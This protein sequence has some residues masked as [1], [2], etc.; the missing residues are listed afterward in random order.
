MTFISSPT[1]TPSVPL[2]HTHST[3]SVPARHN[4]RLQTLVDRINNDEEMRQLWR[5]A[6]VNAVERL[7]LS[8]HGETHIRIVANASLRMLRL[9]M[10]AGQQANIISQHGLGRE[11]AE[12]EVVLA[13]ALHD[14]GLVVHYERHHEYSLPLAY[15]KARELL[16][17]LYATRE[18]VILTSEIL[19]AINS[20]FAE[21]QCLTLEAGILRVAD[22]LDMTKGRSRSMDEPSASAIQE[23][24]LHRGEDKPV[25]IE[26]RMNHPSGISHAGELLQQRLQY[27]RLQDLV[28]VVARIDTG[29]ERRLVPLAM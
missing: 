14:L 23:V 18:R 3:F 16:T 8:D 11:D 10:E 7:G 2:H 22:A 26:I 5:C 28:E 6:N 20:H 17:G 1:I 25:R 21:T 12:L 13:A 4:P 9:L 29:A 27:S 19:H 24:T 15:E